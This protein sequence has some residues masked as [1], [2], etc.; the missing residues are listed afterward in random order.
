MFEWHN[1]SEHKVLTPTFDLEP[2]KYKKGLSIDD[3]LNY[4]IVT[5]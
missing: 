3:I 1:W 4:I 5:Q 2:F